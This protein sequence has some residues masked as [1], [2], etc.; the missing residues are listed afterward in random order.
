MV[1]RGLPARGIAR[2]RDGLW[3]VNDARG[4]WYFALLPAGGAVAPARSGSA[5]RAL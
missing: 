4:E 1:G 3:A 2:V 5:V